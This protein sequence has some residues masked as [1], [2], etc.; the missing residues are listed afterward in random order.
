MKLRAILFH[1]HGDPSRVCRCETLEVAEPVRGEVVVRMLYAPINPADINVIQGTYAT[2]P[3]LPAVPGGE[4]L[5]IVD[6]VGSGVNGLLEGDRVL[7]PAG[8]GSWREFAVAP[9]SELI[10]VAPDLPEQQA[11]ML[12][13]NPATAY[14]MLHDFLDLQPGEWIVQNAANSGVGRS[15]IQIAKARGWRTLNVVRRP[16][17]VEELQAVGADVVLVESAELAGQ[18]SQATES[19]PIRLALNAVGGES[20]MRLASCLAPS[21]TLV[22]YG[23][24]SRQP[25]R[26]PNGLLIFKDLRLRGF[27]VTQWYREASPEARQTMIDELATWVN[28]RRL[29][30]PVDRVFPLEEA[31]AALSRAMEGGRAGKVLFRM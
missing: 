10:R 13:V 15:V 25:L 16:E 27:W 18:V 1:E 11:A 22:T 7:M 5:G 24:M 8:L 28:S 3:P 17:L 9:A 4:G 30:T 21:G 14:R 2:K 12:R 20:A 19:V 26:I 23:A 31:T 6:R 29:F